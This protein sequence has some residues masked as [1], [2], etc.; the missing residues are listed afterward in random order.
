MAAFRLRVQDESAGSLGS[1]SE[2]FAEVDIRETPNSP[3][4]GIPRKNLTTE[5]T[6]GRMHGRWCSSA[7]RDGAHGRAPYLH[8]S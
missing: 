7:Q 5:D 4:S 6:Q 8:L 1:I 2:T 3:F